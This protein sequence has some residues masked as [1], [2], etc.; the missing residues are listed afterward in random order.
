MAAPQAITG[1]AVAN[2]SAQ[3]LAATDSLRFVPDA[4]IP[5]IDG[6]LYVAGQSAGSRTSAKYCSD[7]NGN[8]DIGNNIGFGI[9]IGHHELIFDIV[10]CNDIVRYVRICKQYT[11]IYV[12]SQMR[13]LRTDAI[14]RRRMAAR[15]VYAVCTVKAHVNGT[16]KSDNNIR[17]L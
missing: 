2:R 13:H 14:D 1:A 9:N 17:T 15:A 11:S 10:H 5:E 8:N 16:R 4:S 12:S 7:Y 3:C 6:H